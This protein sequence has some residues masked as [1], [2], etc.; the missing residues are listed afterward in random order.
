MQMAQSQPHSGKF[1]IVTGASTG[2]G[3][4]LAKYC[5]RDGMDLLVVADEQE[6]EQAAETDVVERGL[7]KERELVRAGAQIAAYQKVEMGDGREFRLL[8][9]Q[10]A[11]EDV[12]NFFE[13]EEP[14]RSS[15]YV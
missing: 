9:G 6:I 8:R 13:I 10:P 3:L 2:I 12:D 14:E 11:E 15:R 1:S 4:E 5:A 7:H